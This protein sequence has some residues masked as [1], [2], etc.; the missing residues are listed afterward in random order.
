M[1]ISLHHC[2]NS[3]SHTWKKLYTDVQP[4]K[5]TPFL[6]QGDRYIFSSSKCIERFCKQLMYTANNIEEIYTSYIPVSVQ[7]DYRRMKTHLETIAIPKSIFPEG[8]PKS[9]EDIAMRFNSNID[10][11]FKIKNVECY[12]PIHSGGKDW[13]G[14]D[15]F[16]K[17]KFSPDILSF[18]NQLYTPDII[19][20]KAGFVHYMRFT[21]YENNS[22]VGGS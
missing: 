19:P 11:I 15:V 21:R 5:L 1:I 13:A 8:P 12:P 18:I 9:G 4:H 14:K 7:H 16:C 20:V 3:E 6:Y 22:K 2:D 10:E 17:G